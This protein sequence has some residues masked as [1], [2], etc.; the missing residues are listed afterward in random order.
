[1]AIQGEHS[2]SENGAS[3]ASKAGRKVREIAQSMGVGG[4][5]DQIA[6]QVERRAQ[7]AYNSM[8]STVQDKP[9]MAIGIAAAT[10]LI[11]G[12]MVARR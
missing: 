7:S 9:A 5:Y 3:I 12:M 11:I 10:G 8:K 6:S 2:A 1:M 4:D